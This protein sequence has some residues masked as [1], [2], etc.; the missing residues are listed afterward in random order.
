MR[1]LEAARP[2]TKEECGVY[3][4]TYEGMLVANAECRD[5][6][7]EYL[8]WMTWPSPT[9]DDDNETRIRDLSFR[10]TFNDEPAW[11]DLP[12]YR[13]IVRRY[14]KPML[15]SLPSGATDADRMAEASR[16]QDLELL[17]EQNENNGQ[18]WFDHFLK[19]P[20]YV[21]NPEHR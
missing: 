2:I 18:G 20:Y 1:L 13:I 21:K 7:A 15:A 3:F 9:P 12:K 8:A 11:R 16:N 4:S 5:C 6:E 14:R 10:S 17:S 19:H